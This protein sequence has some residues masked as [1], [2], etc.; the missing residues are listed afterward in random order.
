VAAETENLRFL[1]AGAGAVGSGLGGM[2]S[3]AGHEVALL[4]RNREHMEAVRSSGL[5]LSGYG[6]TTSR[7]ASASSKARGTPRPSTT[8]SS[9]RSPSTPKASS[10]RSPRTNPARSS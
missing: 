9:R 8:F 3:L 2:L 7:A 6:A 5:R 4:G 10:T 1:V